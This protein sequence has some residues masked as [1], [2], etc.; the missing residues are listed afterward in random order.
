MNNNALPFRPQATYATNAPA[1][2]VPKL[3]DAID[4]NQVDPNYQSIYNEFNNNLNYLNTRLQ[5]AQNTAQASQK[6]IG[7]VYNTNTTNAE[8]AYTA[9]LNTIQQSNQDAQLANRLR[10]RASGGAP[11]SGFYDLANRTDNQTQRDVAGAGNT[12][13]SAY[14]E[15]N[16]LASQA[17]TQIQ[18]SLNDVLAGIQNDATLSMRQ[19]DSAI[20][21]ARLQAA[22]Q[23]A[24]LQSL[25]G[26]GDVSSSPDVNNDP[27]VSFEVTDNGMSGDNTGL[28]SVLGLSTTSETPLWDRLNQAQTNQ[29]AGMQSIQANIGTSL[30]DPLLRIA[31][32]FGVK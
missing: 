28:A 10:A 24:Y 25:L 16:N 9:N 23:A 4:L 1:L 31:G 15:A 22:Q 12:L 3:P 20:N 11:S 27:M 30:A 14:S 19:K 29:R 26:G 7:D 5:N 21:S 17:Y 18:A 32:L 6:N 8:N 2:N 13:Q